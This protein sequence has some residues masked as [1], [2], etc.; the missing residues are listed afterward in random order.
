GISKNTTIL[1]EQYN[2][3]R[4]LQIAITTSLLYNDGDDDDL[5]I[6]TVKPENTPFG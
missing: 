3:D 5:H 1:V 6:L 4:D 2:K